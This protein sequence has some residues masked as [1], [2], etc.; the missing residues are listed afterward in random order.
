MTL[1]FK[2]GTHP[3]FPHHVCR[4]RKEPVVGQL[5]EIVD[6]SIHGSKPFRVV[7]RE[8]KMHVGGGPIYFVE[9]M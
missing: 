9:R 8:V 4:L 2:V 5:F 6:K 1:R 3:A 7:L